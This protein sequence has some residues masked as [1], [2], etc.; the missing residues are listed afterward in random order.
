MIVLF[1]YIL[2]KVL[3][4]CDSVIFSFGLNFAVHYRSPKINAVL[5]QSKRNKR[6]NWQGDER[7]ALQTA[8]GTQ[9]AV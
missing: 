6:Q 3:K 7:S 2:S 1:I 4:L 5:R 9:I 8:E